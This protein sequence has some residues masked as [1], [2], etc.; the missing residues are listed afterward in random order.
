ML[1]NDKRYSLFIQIIY[2]DEKYITLAPNVKIIKIISSAFMI[3][4]DKLER[5]SFESI[6]NL[7]L[8]V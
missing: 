8:Y 5:L 2:V 1:A 7:F 4:I 6:F 3:W